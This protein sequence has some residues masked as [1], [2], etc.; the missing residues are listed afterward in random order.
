MFVPLALAIGRICL[1]FRLRASER[2]HSEILRLSLWTAPENGLNCD[3]RMHHVCSEG[4]MKSLAFDVVLRLISDRFLC[5]GQVPA[6][7]S[8][9]GHAVDDDEGLGEFCCQAAVHQVE[10]VSVG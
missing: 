7:A 9:V 4:T 8:I 5:A 3:D 6:H 2:R 10:E 1:H